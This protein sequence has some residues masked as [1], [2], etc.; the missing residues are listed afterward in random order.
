MCP[1]LL[2]WTPNWTFEHC[3]CYF[4]LFLLIFINYYKLI[5]FLSIGRGIKDDLSYSAI[6]LL[7]SYFILLN[8]SK[9][10]EGRST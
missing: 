10:R 1:T 8:I 7:D 3:K 5:L 6:L 2:L 9:R 4:N